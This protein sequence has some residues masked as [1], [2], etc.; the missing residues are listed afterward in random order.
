[1]GA[2]TVE[3]LTAEYGQVL[4]GMRATFGTGKTKSLAWRRQQLEQLHLMHVENHE[5]MT[6]AVRQDL[7]G[8]K[9]RGLGELAGAAGADHML[10]HLDEYT[11][12]KWVA[13]WVHRQCVRPEPKGVM[14]I[15]APWNFPI[16]L[17][18]H[19]L[20]PA[21]AAGN[22]VVI[23]PSEMSPASSQMLKT[24]LE[25]YM[26]N[27]CIKVIEGAKDETTALLNLQWDHI[28]YTGNTQVGRIVMTAAAKHLTPVTLELG[29]KSPVIV[30]E[31]AQLD[32]TCARVACAKWLNCGQI[33]VAPDYVLV[34]ESK[35][36][37]F[38]KRTKDIIKSSYGDS[39]ESPDW[40][41][42]VNE[43]HVDRLQSL[44]ETSG[45]NVICGGVDGIDRTDRFIPPTVISQPKLDAPIMQ[46]EIFGPVL[47]VL[48]Y[49][50]LDAALDMVKGQETP[51]ALY[52]YSETSKNVEKVLQECPSGGSC[53]NSSLE[54]LMG[55][56]MPFGGKGP[57]GMGCYHG[58]FGF[59]EFSHYRSV[60]R[61]STLPLF[62]GPFAPLPSA[63]NPT[64]EFVYNLAI[65]ITLGVLPRGLKAL[66]RRFPIGSVMKAA[67]LAAAMVAARQI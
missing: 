11:S 27:D 32:A 67:L 41:R 66:M 26:D 33:C 43:R 25:K 18:L 38:L 13:G 40:G 37:E 50:N 56:S 6:A 52:V 19:P 49:K 20:A 5:A 34:H 2:A 8:P 44:I 55:E 24:L 36:Q 7:G 58:K 23:K 22:M 57:S 62:R 17:C 31:S 51:L 3:S 47:P 28:M 63:E 65:K 10:D 4:A 30:D 64:P 46:D 42:I 39:K 35:E 48:S 60:L 29:G 61:K 53:V 1:M 21:I 16:T 15:I 9:L 45:G 14:L 54:Q 12:E 59:D